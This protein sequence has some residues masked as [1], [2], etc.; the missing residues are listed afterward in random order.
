MTW[1]PDGNG[2]FC[3]SVTGSN[4]ASDSADEGRRLRLEIEP[5]FSFTNLPNCSSVADALDAVRLRCFPA[6]GKSGKVICCCSL[7][8]CF[9][10]EA[11][12]FAIALGINPQISNAQSRQ[13]WCRSQYGTK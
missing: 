11:R 2:L 7:T 1:L 6:L 3:C 9:W 5:A 13:F 4:A 12:F 8:A 10:L